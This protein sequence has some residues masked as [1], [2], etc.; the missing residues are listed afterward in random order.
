M[1]LR[2]L[3]TTL[4][5]LTLVAGTASAQDT[6][7]EKGKLSYALGYD[8]GRNLVESGESIDVN[9]VIKAVQDGYAKQEPAVPVDQLRSAV[10]NM[11]QRQMAKAQAEFDT[12]AAA[13]KAK[14]D[15]YLA[16]NTAKAGVKTL[17]RGV[18][19]RVVATGNGAKPNQASDVSLNYKGTPASGGQ[20]FV[21]TFRPPEGRTEEPC[22]GKE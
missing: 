5:A 19:Y 4:A 11:Q 22:F 2:L 16:Q 21:D 6:S 18:Q 17:P 1:K 12:D 10:Q 8:L 3:A 9:T 20:T 15:A 13:N 14:S 7:S